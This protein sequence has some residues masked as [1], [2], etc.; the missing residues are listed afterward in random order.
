MATKVTFTVDEAT[1]ARL[2]EA[3]ARLALPK[4][5]IVR[6]AILAF[7]ERIGKLSARERLSKLRALDE[8]FAR[9]ASADSSAVD[10]E[11]RQLREARRSGGRR[12][13]GKTPGKRRNP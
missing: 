12:S 2:D 11:L 6:E 9:P 13:G 8:F 10:R 5:Q 3:S 4:S 7:Y 1:V